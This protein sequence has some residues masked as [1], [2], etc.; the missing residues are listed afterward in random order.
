MRSSRMHAACAAVRVC[1]ASDSIAT[2]T[3]AFAE[4]SF[5]MWTC[6]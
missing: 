2:I 5:A 1:P 3:V 4:F 6:N